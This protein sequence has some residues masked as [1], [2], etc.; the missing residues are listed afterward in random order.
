MLR[1]LVARIVL[2]LVF[3][4]AALKLVPAERLPEALRAGREEFV[5]AQALGE[6]VGRDGSAARIGRSL[7]RGGFAQA[8]SRRAFHWLGLVEEAAVLLPDGGTIQLKGVP[9]NDAWF[10]AYDLYP[11]RVVG[12]TA[13]EGSTL[14]DDSLPGVDLILLGSEPPRLERAGE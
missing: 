10:L 14:E 9:R 12:L 8:R 1:T 2:V 13:E 5:G 4:A 3:A 6:A 11:R 7:L